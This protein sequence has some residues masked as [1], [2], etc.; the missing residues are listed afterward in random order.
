M[1]LDSRASDAVALAIGNAV[2]IYVAQAVLD[3]A[4]LDRDKVVPQVAPTGPVT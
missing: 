2:P 3:E 1:R 4:G